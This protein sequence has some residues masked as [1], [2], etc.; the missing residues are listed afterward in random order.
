MEADHDSP[1][2]V[3]ARIRAAVARHYERQSAYIVTDPIPDPID[4]DHDDAALLLQ[5]QDRLARDLRW[6]RATRERVEARL[7]SAEADVGTMLKQ[8]ALIRKILAAEPA[9]T[10]APAVAETWAHI[11]RRV[12][13]VMDGQATT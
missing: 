1:N 11:R 9:G 10:V 3:I 2:H 7:R 8:C 6:E 5:G 12:L 13:A 4:V